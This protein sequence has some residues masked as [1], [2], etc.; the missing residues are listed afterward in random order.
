M[1]GQRMLEWLG[2]VKETPADDDIV[3][4]GHKKAHLHWQKKHKND[5]KWTAQEH[6]SMQ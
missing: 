6:E 1:P 3:V 4:E 2:E 5:A